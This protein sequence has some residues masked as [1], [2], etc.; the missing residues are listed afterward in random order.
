MRLRPIILAGALALGG[1][2][3]SPGKADA[4]VSFSV[5]FGSPYD[6]SWGFPYTYSRPIYGYWSN[7]YWSSPYRTLGYSSPYWYGRTY[8]YADPFFGT[9]YNS[10]YYANPGWG[11]GRYSYRFGRWR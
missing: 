2:L 10:F 4:Q 9:R 6:Y 1:L 7:P 3:V 8:G 11:P 5:G